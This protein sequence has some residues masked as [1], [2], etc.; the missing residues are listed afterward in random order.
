MSNDQ[1]K[2]I[3]TCEAIT[4]DTEIDRHTQDKVITPLLNSAAVVV[5]PDLHSFISVLPSE[6]KLLL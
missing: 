1:A 4:Q 3:L 6:G 5:A 2:V